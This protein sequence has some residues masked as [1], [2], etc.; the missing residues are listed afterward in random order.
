MKIENPTA[1]NAADRITRDTNAPTS[2]AEARGRLAADRRAARDAQRAAEAAVEGARLDVPIA[3]LEER[4]AH[5]GAMVFDLVDA[6]ARA[7]G[8]TVHAEGTLPPRLELRVSN[9][10]LGR[11]DDRL[12]LQRED[13]LLRA[14]FIG[15]SRMEQLLI[16]LDG[17]T[18]APEPAARRLAEAWCAHIELSQGGLH[19]TR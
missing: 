12:I 13:G 14:S 10:L 16:E 7:F 17:P 8:I 3:V 5:T 19:V 9:G 18:F 11:R 15:A 1:A 6:H 2:W 4:F